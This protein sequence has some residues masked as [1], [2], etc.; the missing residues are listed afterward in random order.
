MCLDQLRFY[1]CPVYITPKTKLHSPM[2]SAFV[3]RLEIQL[4][5]P[6]FYSSLVTNAAVMQK[7]L[8]DGT[9]F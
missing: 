1:N 8:E 5:D 7:P 2:V 6:S 9:Q 4:L 3:T